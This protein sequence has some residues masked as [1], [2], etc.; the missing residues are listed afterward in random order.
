MESDMARFLIAWELGEGY[1]HLGRHLR[2]AAWLRER[3]HQ[4]TFALKDL[5]HAEYALGRHGYTLLQAPVWL[6]TPR[7]LPHAASYPEILF[8]AGFL[9]P[10][11]LMGKV[12][13]WRGLYGLVGP[14]VVIF[15][16]APTALLA[17]RGQGLARAVSGQGF[18]CPPRTSP[19]PG[20][21]PGVSYP[22]QRLAASEAR[23]LECVNRLCAQA[24]EPPLEKLADL[25]DVERDF[26]CTFAELDTYREHRDAARYLGP[27]FEADHGE[28][29][30]WPRRGDA[31]VFGYVK[32]RY[33][34][35]E[36]MLRELSRSRH[37]ILLHAPGIPREL[38]ERYRSPGLAFVLR[39]AR[40]SAVVAEADAV[41]CHAGHGT[42][43]ATLLAGRPLLL[44]PTQVEQ[45]GLAL[46]VSALGAGLML[47]PRR[48]PPDHAVVVDQLVV[49]ER[50][51]EGAAAFARAHADFDRAARLDTI[52]GA[53]EALAG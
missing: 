35:F 34:A 22:M 38:V 30:R 17:A 25:F 36:A 9:D 32:P 39:P 26:L 21:L 37:A 8:R 3:G 6:H 19:L 14:D 1:G 27:D 42:V 49:D 23:V 43:C 2:V 18:F 41:V 15:D 5:A 4:V 53:L 13:A 7:G 31:R 48:R 16:H 51:R 47:D 33:H 20:M 29:P 12:R 45:H 50:F 10:D 24:G 46:R 28:A 40:M 11:G 44:L 52:G